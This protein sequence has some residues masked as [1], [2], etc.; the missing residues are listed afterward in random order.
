MRATVG[1]QSVLSKVRDMGLE[2][3]GMTMSDGTEFR[4]L[5]DIPELV[6]AIEAYSRWA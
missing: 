6:Q 4:V 3:N 1:C 2:Y 5:M